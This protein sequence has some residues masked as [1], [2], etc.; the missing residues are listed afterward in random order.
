M[1]L[2]G[3]KL[4]SPPLKKNIYI[5]IYNV[6]AFWTSVCSI[7]VSVHS[8]LCMCASFLHPEDWMFS[9]FSG[10]GTYIQTFLC[11]SF[12][13]FLIMVGIWICN[14]RYCLYNKFA[15]DIDESS[16]NADVICRISSSSMVHKD[17]NCLRCCQGSC[18]SS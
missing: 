6:Y 11:D 15:I 16:S 2:C 10:G 3:I 14:S 9:C 13:S 4:R 1:L 8:S 5:S 7:L 17:E 12:L 18:L